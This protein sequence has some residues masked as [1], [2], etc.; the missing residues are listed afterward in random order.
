MKLE[1][2]IFKSLAEI[3]L[4]AIQKHPVP[5]TSAITEECKFPNR[6]IASF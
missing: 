2:D 5:C 1:P 4:A 6:H 3:I